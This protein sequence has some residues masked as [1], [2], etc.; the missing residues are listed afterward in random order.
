MQQSLYRIY[1]K[2]SHPHEGTTSVASYSRQWQK[3][4]QQFL[5][6]ELLDLPALGAQ[7]ECILSEQYDLPDGLQR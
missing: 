6:L 7:N 4:G 2:I 3:N 5:T 1:L